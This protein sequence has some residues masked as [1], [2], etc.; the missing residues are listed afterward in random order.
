MLD[1]ACSHTDQAS[2]QILSEEVDFG[3]NPIDGIWP[4]SLPLASL[5]AQQGSETGLQP[6]N[7]LN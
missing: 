2:A 5:I 6:L 4:N 3:R 1:R 7:A